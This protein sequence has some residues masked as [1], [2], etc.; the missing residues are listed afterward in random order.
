MEDKQN[1]IYFVGHFHSNRSQGGFTLLE[2]IIVLLLMCLILSLSTIHFANGLPSSHFNATI[3]EMLATIRH[4]RSLAMVNN[5]N[6]IITIDLDQK[7]YS[8]N[9]LKINDI[10][11]DI[12]IKIKDDLTGEILKGKYLMLFRPGGTT[13]GG[14]LILWSNKKKQSIQVDPLVGAT[15]L[16]NENAS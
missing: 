10:P 3:R 1:L 15:T 8:I 5:E 11:S 12:N 6:R 4:A 16:N 2:I 9:G 13:E 14:T 7:K